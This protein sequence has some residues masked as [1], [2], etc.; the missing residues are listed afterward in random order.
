LLYWL[1]FTLCAV[2]NR[3]QIATDFLIVFEEEVGNLLILVDSFSALAVDPACL[4]AIITEAHKRTNMIA[5]KMA[6]VGSIE[7]ITTK[8]VTFQVRLS[9]LLLSVPQRPLDEASPPYPSCPDRPH[10]VFF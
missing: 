2:T 9:C 3:A 4:V 6:T 5:T 8:T 7:R 10:V 1:G